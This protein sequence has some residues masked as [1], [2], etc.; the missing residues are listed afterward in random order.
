VAAVVRR[1][2]EQGGTF[3]IAAVRPCRTAGRRLLEVADDAGRTWTGGAFVFAAG[4]W[5]P[6]LFPRLLGGLLR[7]TKQDVLFVGSPGGD[8]R[9]EAEAL[10]CWVDYDRACYGIP[11]VDGRA[12]KLAPDRLGPVW[13]PVRG[14]RLVD[15]ESVRLVREYL[16]QRFPALAGQPVVDSRVCQYSSTP[17]THFVIDRHP[18]LDN[19]WLV[20]GGSGHGF[21]H[22]P[23][24]GRH[25]VAR[26]D[27][28]P[29]PEDD[30]FS[31]LRPRSATAG[32]RTG[33]DAMAATWEG[34]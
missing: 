6:R 29:A 28:A 13:D 5:L 8:R 24:I 1:V 3:E 23:A 30:R 4:P 11:G 32:P 31:V 33:G 12:F 26:L 16:A 2:V 34:Y 21:K 18:E 10:P 27:G 15:P 7:V 19:V 20:G 17:D 9:W 22:G 14:E 25:V